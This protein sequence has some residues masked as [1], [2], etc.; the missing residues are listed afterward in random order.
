MFGFGKNKDK[1]P[2]KEQPE[3]VVE[4]SAIAKNE[5]I[6]NESNDEKSWLQRLSWS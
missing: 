4:V 1:K 6:T 5:I 2:L 3:A